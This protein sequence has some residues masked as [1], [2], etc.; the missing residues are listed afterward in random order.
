MLPVCVCDAENELQPYRNV[1]RS[2]QYYSRQSVYKTDRV[3]SL[4]NKQQTLKLDCRL[5]SH[6]YQKPCVFAC[7][8]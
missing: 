2:R 5:I 4:D 6:Y 1:L 3:H 8:L 7:G